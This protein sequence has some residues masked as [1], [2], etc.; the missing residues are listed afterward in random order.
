MWKD[1]KI[2][3]MTATPLYDKPIEIFLLNKMLY[4]DENKYEIT[5]KNFYELF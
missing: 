4:N 5:K 1:S 3:L 2:C